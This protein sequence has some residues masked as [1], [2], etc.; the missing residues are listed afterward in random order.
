MLA[1]IQG[2]IHIRGILDGAQGN[3]RWAPTKA[4]V[5]AG[6]ELYLS[7]RKNNVSKLHHKLMVIDEQVIIA[8]SF[9]Y[10]EPATS[11]N[12]ENILVIGD[13]GEDDPT[14]VGKQQQLAKYALAEFDRIIR[15]HSYRAAAG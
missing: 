15:D 8:G 3:Q 7:N 11:L 10:T 6:A 2:G 13:L 9:N 5:N 1:L 4:L 12:D 14:L